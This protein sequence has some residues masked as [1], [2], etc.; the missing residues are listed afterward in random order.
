[1]QEVPNG[2]PTPEQ[3]GEICREIRKDWSEKEHWIRSGYADG[4][5]VLTVPTIRWNGGGVGNL[6]CKK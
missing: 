1:M 5:P 3:I 2:D 4:R 6:N